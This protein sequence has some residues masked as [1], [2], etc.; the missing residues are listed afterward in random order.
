MA[1]IILDLVVLICLFHKAG[2][3]L[4]SKYSDRSNSRSSRMEFILEQRKDSK[5]K[6]IIQD[7]N[8][9]Q[10]VKGDIGIIRF[11][12]DIDQFGTRQATW[13]CS[14]PLFVTW[15]YRKSSWNGTLVHTVF[16]AACRTFFMSRRFWSL[17]D[18]FNI[19]RT[20]PYHDG[21]REIR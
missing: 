19:H 16:Y 15:V 18:T 1:V 2:S 21:S 13:F 11:T 9:S 10:N 14:L 4:G 6:Q 12:K 7:L 20:K 17:V 3:I 8:S 5:P